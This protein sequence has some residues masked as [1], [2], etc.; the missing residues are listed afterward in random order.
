MWAGRAGKGIPQPVANA[1][2]ALGLMLAGSNDSLLN[3]KL[4]WL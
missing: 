4:K 3:H 1:S 2:N